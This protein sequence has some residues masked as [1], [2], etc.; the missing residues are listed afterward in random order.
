M[1]PSLSAADKQVYDAEALKATLVTL[2]L[3]R[4]D[5]RKARARLQKEIDELQEAV[6][7]L[8]KEHSVLSQINEL[9]FAVE[10]EGDN[11]GAGEAGGDG[12]AP[13]ALANARFRLI[14]RKLELTVLNQEIKSCLSS[15]E[16]ATLELENAIYP[17]EREAK[18][19]QE[20]V[21]EAPEL[22]KLTPEEIDHKIGD[23]IEARL[24]M[25]I[26]AQ[27]NVAEAEATKISLVSDVQRAR[28]TLSMLLD[29][30]ETM[31]IASHRMRLAYLTEQAIIKKLDE[32]HAKLRE[33]VGAYHDGLGWQT[34]A[35]V[36]IAGS[37]SGRIEKQLVTKALTPWVSLDQ[38][39]RIDPAALA[40][41]K[42]MDN[43]DEKGLNFEAFCNLCNRIVTAE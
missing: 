18:S 1:N 23:L 7:P 24:M 15:Y 5:Q 29:E 22:F 28:E 21:E 41:E 31:N 19:A 33:R 35:F 11:D 34:E 14:D 32:E 3:Q 39:R 42:E 27:Q 30:R 40:E 37:T 6:E 8:R 17:L 13:G 9:R 43:G 2:K 10:E 20:K 12:N 36:S 25:K 38:M 16:R 26:K 4:L